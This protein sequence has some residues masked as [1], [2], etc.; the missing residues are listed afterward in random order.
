M[1][2]WFARRGVRGCG[3]VISNYGK[4]SFAFPSAQ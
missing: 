3:V 4:A 1:E 2:K